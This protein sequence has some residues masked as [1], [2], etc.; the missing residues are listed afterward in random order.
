MLI[1][2]AIISIPVLIMLGYMTAR[3]GRFRVG[4][5]IMAAS[6]SSGF[7]LLQ[8]DGLMTLPL[9]SIFFYLLRPVY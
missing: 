7:F 2:L 5:L 3:T 6:L 9:L 1:K 4:Y 8:L